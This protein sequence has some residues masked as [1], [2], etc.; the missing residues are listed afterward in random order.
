M[1]VF[2]IV[3]IAMLIFAG[4]AIH[5][6]IKAERIE[7]AEFMAYCQSKGNN[8]ED[9]KWEYKRFK[10]GQKTNTIIMPMPILIG[11]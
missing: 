4:F 5:D 2:G 10:N 1:W 7:K 11:R 6:G 9:C 8:A 3:V